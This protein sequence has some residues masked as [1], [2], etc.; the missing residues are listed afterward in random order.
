MMAHNCS[1]ENL[2]MQPIMLAHPEY[3]VVFPSGWDNKTTPAM[4]AQTAITIPVAAD[5]TYK[6]TLNMT[7][8]AYEMQVP[9]PMGT[10]FYR[11]KH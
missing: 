6:P 4:K 2:Q 5:L 10:R 9:S 7:K 8:L 11:L 1:S 3:L